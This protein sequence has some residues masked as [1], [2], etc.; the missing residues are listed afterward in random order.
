[1]IINKKDIEYKQVQNSWIEITKY[2]LDRIKNLT[3]PEKIDNKT[4]ISIGGA[5]FSRCWIRTLNLPNKLKAIKK[6]AFSWN[7]IQ[8]INLPKSLEF[9]GEYSFY[10]NKIEKITFNKKLNFLGQWALKKNNLSSLSLP[11]KISIIPTK[12]TQTNPNLKVVKLPDSLKKIEVFAFEWCPVHTF[13]KAFNRMEIE[14]NICQKTL[15]NNEKVLLKE[16]EK[17][18]KKKKVT[19]SVKNLV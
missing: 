10:N 2:K 13:H 3:I 18:P 7:S 9:L 6:H 11:N 8:T 17:K 1:M 19:I 15:W 4:V 12:L 16:L 5:A 14:K